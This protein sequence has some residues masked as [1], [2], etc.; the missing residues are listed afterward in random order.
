F[1]NSVCQ[2]T[3]QQYEP[4]KAA[5]E[6]SMKLTLKKF[7]EVQRKM[8]QGFQAGQRPQYPDP[9]KLISEALALAVK[10]T[11]SVE[12]SRRY[13]VELE[14]RAAAR[15]RVAVINLVA[16]LDKELVL[17]ADQRTKVTETL[18]TNWSDAWGQQLEVFL[19]GDQY[20]PIPPDA[21][22]LPILNDK[23]KEVWKG[24]PRN[25][26]MIWGWVGFGFVQAMDIEEAVP[27]NADKA[28][29]KEAKKG[30]SP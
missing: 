20:L 4:I 10:Q 17:T 29:D 6:V 16:K 23:Q 27:A 25:Q 21:Q 18:N 8:Q 14:R 5:G 1:V 7:A 30:D 24:I 11:L 12:Q 26:N 2:P 9:R 15:R 3:P 19:Y 22:V 13:E 28:E